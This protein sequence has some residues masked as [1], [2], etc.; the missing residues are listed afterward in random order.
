M[1]RDPAARHPSLL[2]DA[3]LALAALGAV[4]AMLAG[5]VGVFSGTVP[6]YAE[7]WYGGP[8][9]ALGFLLSVGAGLAAVLRGSVWGAMLVASP[10]IFVVLASLLGGGNEPMWAAWPAIPF[11]I[12]GLV[13][14]LATTRSLPQERW[15][16]PA[17]TSER[18]AADGTAHAADEPV[19]VRRIAGRD[20]IEPPPGIGVT[21]VEVGSGADDPTSTRAPD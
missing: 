10:A 1:N 3:A 4:P 11:V 9:I 21:E 19:T 17:P 16:A 7:E 8:L 14:V 6:S 5:V 20:P 18:A 13:I 2:A 15:V 12:V